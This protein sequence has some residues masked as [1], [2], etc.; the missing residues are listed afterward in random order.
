MH[1]EVNPSY[2]TALS[3]QVPPSKEPELK[4]RI[5][6]VLTRVKEGAK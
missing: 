6:P 4:A 2:F 5:W 3:I 1:S